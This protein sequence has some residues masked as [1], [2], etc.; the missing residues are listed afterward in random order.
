MCRCWTA[1][2]FLCL[3]SGAFLS[4]FDRHAL[5]V[6][7]N[8]QSLS[9]VRV[10]EC[11]KRNIPIGAELSPVF[12]EKKSEQGLPVAAHNVSFSSHLAAS[13]LSVCVCVCVCQATPPPP[14]SLSV[15]ENKPFLMV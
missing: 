15:F 11:E 6:L 2:V 8:K 7:L 10:T 4:T 5:F 12:H 13:L 1:A 14:P 3:C 9:P